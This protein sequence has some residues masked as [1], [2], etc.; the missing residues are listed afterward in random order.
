MPKLKSL[1][2]QLMIDALSNNRDGVK[3]LVMVFATGESLKV[4]GMHELLVNK[5][6][7]K[8]FPI[9]KVF[10]GLSKVSTCSVVGLFDFK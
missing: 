9:H 8:S 6:N 2:E 3:T 5:K 7:M 10:D 1:A 4:D